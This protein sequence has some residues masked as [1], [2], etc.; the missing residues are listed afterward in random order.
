MGRE[1]IPELGQT[2]PMCESAIDPA[3]DGV[4]VVGEV[5]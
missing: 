3:V 2:S 1:R 5:S 4:G